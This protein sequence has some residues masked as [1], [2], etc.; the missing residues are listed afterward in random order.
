VDRADPKPVET[1]SNSYSYNFKNI[2]EE[3]RMETA[4]VFIGLTVAVFLPDSLP[5]IR[6]SFLFRAVGTGAYGLWILIPILDPLEIVALT[7][8]A[9]FW[10]CSL[11]VWERLFEEDAVPVGRRF[12]IRIYVR[13][14][15]GRIAEEIGM[16]L[17]WARKRG[18]SVDRR[19]LLSA[20]ALSI[21]SLGL[22]SVSV[23]VRRAPH[24]VAAIA[25]SDRFAIV[26][27]G[28]LAA[29]FV[30]S[31]RKSCERAGRHSA[32]RSLAATPGGCY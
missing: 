26:V 21:A 16:V 9:I 25:A 11:L 31:A 20:S 18:K 3:Y 1:W 6:R 32:W 17:E 8:M 30:V 14:I 29:T 23:D 28:F 24:N 13:R 19:S 2:R 15:A 5:H 10:S 12:G 7:L 27:S 22:L 4:R